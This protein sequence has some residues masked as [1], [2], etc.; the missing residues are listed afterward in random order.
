MIKHF[1]G[2]LIIVLLVGCQT[3]SV[4]LQYDPTT[5]GAEYIATKLKATLKKQGYKVTDKNGTF[6]IRLKINDTCSAESYCVESHSNTIVVT[7]GDKT[8]LIYGGFDVEEQLRFGSDLS[9]VLCRRQEPDLAFRALKFN[10]P[11]FAYRSN[12]AIT[13]HYETCKSLDFWESFLDMMVQ[14]RFNALTLWN[15]HPFPYMIRPTHFPYATSFSDEELA[16]WKKLYHGI[17]AMAKERGIDTY[18]VNWNIFVSE[19]FAQEHQLPRLGNISLQ[20]GGID[21]EVVELA[22][23]YNKECVT[24]VLNE[25][26]NLT[27]FGLSLGEAMGGMTVE[28]RQAWINETIIA[29]MADANRKAKLIHRV[30]FSAGL[31]NGGTTSKSTEIHTREAIE[32]IKGVQ[33]PI[34][35]EAKFNWSHAHSSTKLIKVHGGSLSDTYWNPAPTNYKMNWMAR[36]EDFFCLRWAVPDFVRSHIQQNTHDY[37]GGYY[38]GSE[39]YIPALDYFTSVDNHGEWQYAFER[40]WQFYMI[41]GRL[42]YDKDMDNS[43]F[44]KETVYRYGNKATNLLKAQSLA[45]QMPLHYASFIDVNNDKSLYSEG[46][47]ARDKKDSSEFLNLNL[48]IQKNSLDP[49]YLSIRKYVDTLLAGGCFNSRAIT[50]NDLADSLDRLSAEALRL[51][52]DIDPGNSVSLFYELQD[53]KAWAALMRYFADKVR[54]G[55]ALYTF[56]KTGDTDKQDIA[57]VFLEEAL[58]HWDEL[59]EITNPI[60]REHPLTHLHL[61]APNNYFHWNLFRKHVEEDVVI[62]KEG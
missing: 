41:W 14:N 58:K 3:N 18:L 1:L 21:P 56:R 29:G 47:L 46:F 44:Q 33:F 53:V 38:V 12:E 52:D 51:I 54:G 40:Q 32:K 39:C 27:G 22:K 5:P 13:Q 4:Q 57:V 55:V 35:L 50:P 37:V 8:G 23:Q 26:P 2:I 9:A 42:L 31:V 11:W 24:Q 28:E 34:W 10:L 30:P 36:N 48:M 7:G 16:E 15:L 60:Y 19:G 62:A 20:K 59:I 45:G 43:V 49:D 6:T 17:F 25:Y 61:Q